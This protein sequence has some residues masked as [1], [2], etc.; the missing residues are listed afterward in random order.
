VLFVL[1]LGFEKEEGKL[2]YDFYVDG[3]LDRDIEN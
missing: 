1:D 2:M 3:F